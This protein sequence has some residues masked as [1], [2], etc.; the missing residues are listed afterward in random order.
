MRP[1]RSPP[2]DGGRH[3]AVPRDAEAE[4][5]DLLIR[6]RLKKLLELDSLDENNFG[7]IV[8]T[9]TRRLTTMVPDDLVVRAICLLFVESLPTCLL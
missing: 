5:V 6:Q 7:R 3:R 8:C 4:A 9:L 2:Q 1:C